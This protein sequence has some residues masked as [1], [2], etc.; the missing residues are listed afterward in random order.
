MNSTALKEAVATGYPRE[1]MYGVW[2]AG[3]EPD[4][5][6]VGADAKG[7]N[8]LALQHGAG[9]A[10]VHADILKFVF[11]KGEGTGPQDQVGQVLY[12]RG[13]I[14]AMLNIEA[15]KQ[16]Q[17]KYGKKPLT[18]EQVRWG[19]ENLNLDQKT[20]DG[21]GF[22]TVMRPIGTTCRDHEG[23]RFARIQTWD[24][25]KW[26]FSSDWY[27]ADEQI[28]KPMV[29]AAALKYAEE[30]KVPVADCAIESQK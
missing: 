20:L 22:A 21:L 16:A 4:V 6:P 26:N 9:Q 27:E 8:A 18:G 11:A 3:A 28:I 17:T 29:N 13:M 25:A 24:G 12:N 10:K 23:A 5:T 19:L 14:N 1:K 7:Y 30:K 15:I 2:W